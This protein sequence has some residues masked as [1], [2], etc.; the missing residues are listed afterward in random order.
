M[1]LCLLCCCCYRTAQNY[2]ILQSL[3]EQTLGLQL[4]RLQPLQPLY[5]LTQHSVRKRYSSGLKSYLMLSPT[6]HTYRLFG[7]VL[8]EYTL[9]IKSQSA[10]KTQPPSNNHHHHPNAVASSDSNPDQT[11]KTMPVAAADSKTMPH[12]E[13]IENRINKIFSSTPVSVVDD[14][15][16]DHSASTASKG[17]TDGPLGA[18]MFLSFVYPLVDL[19][20]S[21]PVS[22]DGGKVFS[23]TVQR[24]DGQKMRVLR[25]EDCNDQLTEYFKVNLTLMFT[26]LED[27]V[28]WKHNLQQQTIAMRPDVIPLA[29]L[30]FEEKR[31]S[32]RSILGR[33]SS[34]SQNGPCLSADNSILS[35]LVLPTASNNPEL[36]ENVKIEIAKTLS[37]LQH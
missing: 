1:M 2:L 3:L 18:D 36:A 8:Y 25:C 20:V 14:D 29:P 22:E 19:L 10:S 16:V 11:T 27:A 7:H 26:A 17:G 13:Y 31:K 34:S 30:T 24:R 12:E 23:I 35:F 28:S 5:G 6:L 4:A 33:P 21:G 32:S 9:S 15:A 37:A